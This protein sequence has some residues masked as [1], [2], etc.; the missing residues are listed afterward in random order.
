MFEILA[1]L[2]YNNYCQPV[3]V[4][5]EPI[6]KQ[7]IL[8]YHS[9]SPVGDTICAGW[10]FR[11]LVH[12]QGFLYSAERKAP[13]MAKRLSP[14]E[15][16]RRNEMFQQGMLWC[17]G[18]Q[19]FHPVNEFAKTSQ[20]SSN[21]GY[22][23][24]CV[25]QENLKRKKWDEV[26]G[27]E[28][29][30]KRLTEIKQR[31]VELAG[32]CCQRCGYNAFLAGLDF[33]HVYRSSKNHPPQIVLNSNNFEKTWRELD[34]CCLLCRNCHSAYE[35]VLWRAKFIKRDNGLGWTVGGDLPL[36]DTRYETDTPP[37]F[38]QAPLPLFVYPP[39]EGKQL[40]LFEGQ[41]SYTP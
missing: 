41:G 5:N 15:Q 31:F 14:L 7:N 6:A 17:V 12:P 10:R 33:H 16:K 36:D 22:R 39:K 34:K 37:K 32:G 11:E 35:A 40:K 1:R 20:S 4:V 30:K 27:K 23:Y 38:E 28:Y 13:K 25:Y 24:N 9:I 3:Q 8:S 29:R 19:S 21:Y 18:C 2:C 26:N